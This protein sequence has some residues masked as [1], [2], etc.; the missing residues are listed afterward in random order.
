V[1]YV[2]QLYGVFWGCASMKCA[3]DSPST[4]IHGAVRRWLGAGAIWG[5]D[6]D[7]LIDL[8]EDYGADRAV[9]ALT[10]NY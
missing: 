8:A 9:A 2:V 5:T 6:A 3:P 1:I 7:P 10:F 4:R